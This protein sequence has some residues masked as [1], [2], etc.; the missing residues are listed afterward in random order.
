MHLLRVS[1]VAEKFGVDPKTVARWSIRAEQNVR[2]G[3]PPSL[4][5]TAI[6]KL[7]TGHRRYKG[8]VIKEILEGDDAWTKDPQTNTSSGA[9]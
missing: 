5:F 4:F 6:V 1:E 2:D 7:P 9:Y 8:H 3:N